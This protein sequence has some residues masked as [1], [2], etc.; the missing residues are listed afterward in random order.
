MILSAL[1]YVRLTGKKNDG[2]QSEFK[3]DKK[4]INSFNVLCINESMNV[5][6]IRND[7]SFLIITYLKDSIPPTGNFSIKNDTLFVNGFEKRNHRNMSLKIYAS[8]T[9]KTIIL[10]NANLS[11]GKSAYEMDQSSVWL[12][13]D[14]TCRFSFSALNIHAM[15]HSEV[16]TAI[17]KVDSLGMNLQN[18]R[19][20]IS[21]K[22]GQINCT[23]S[24]SS[25]IYV[26]RPQAISIKKDAG[27]KINVNDY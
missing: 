23:L 3:S 7:S 8:D 2:L 11:L 25:E 18:S 9:L 13:Q 19:A 1:I 27:S 26:W 16:N 4:L 22:I 6:L 12:N 5:T 15:D 14:T 17:F 21:T 20:N 24:D 10:K